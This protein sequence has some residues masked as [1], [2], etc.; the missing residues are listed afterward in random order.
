MRARGEPSASV[1]N[2]SLPVTLKTYPFSF[3]FAAT[4]ALCALSAADQFTI[5]GTH[6]FKIACA[7]K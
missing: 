4:P 1:L 7:A 6:D 5:I 3:A 2:F